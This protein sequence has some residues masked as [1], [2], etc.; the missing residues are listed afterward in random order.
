LPGAETALLNAWGVAGWPTA[1][2]AARVAAALLDDAPAAGNGPA[3]ATLGGE[4]VLGSGSAFAT[5]RRASVPTA[6]LPARPT[7][8]IATRGPASY[9]VAYGLPTPAPP[10]APRLNLL[11]ELVDPADGTP[12]DPAAL[13]AGQLVGLRLT[14]VVARPIV[15]ADLELPLPAGLAFVAATPRAPFQQVADAGDG[16]VRIGGADLQPGVYTQIVIARAVAPGSFSAPPPRLVLPHEDGRS[17]V[18]PAGFQ[19]TIKE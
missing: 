5:V 8:A 2:D 3:R 11:S 14:A 16:L 18:A 7:L 9:L 15:R 1:F 4:V 13:Q 19:V 10:T 17:V 12:L 6:D